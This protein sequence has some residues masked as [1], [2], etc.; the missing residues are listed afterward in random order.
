MTSLIVPKIGATKVDKTTGRIAQLEARVDDLEETL[1]VM[2]DMLNMNNASLAEIL[3]AVA[4]KT[5]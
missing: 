2:R 5:Q 3:R 4:G 1:D